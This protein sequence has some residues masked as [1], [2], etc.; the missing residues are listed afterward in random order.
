MKTDRPKPYTFIM[1]G[2]QWTRVIERT[3][4]VDSESER[5]G[6]IDAIETVAQSLQGTTSSSGTSN[7][8]HSPASSM[9]STTSGLNRSNSRDSFNNDDNLSRQF[10]NQGISYGTRSGKKKVVSN[11]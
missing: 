8:S 3:F 2:L 6:W 9:L 11:E 1:R 7:F 4:Y 5:E 10:G